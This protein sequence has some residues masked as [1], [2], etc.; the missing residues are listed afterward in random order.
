MF[1]W[2]PGK[3]ST[4]ATLR[5]WFKSY[6]DIRNTRLELGHLSILNQLHY[7]LNI[8][9]VDNIWRPISVALSMMRGK[10]FLKVQEYSRVKTFNF[11]RIRCQLQLIVI[12]KIFFVISIKLIYQRHAR[13]NPFHNVIFIRKL[14]FF[15]WSSWSCLSTFEGSSSHT[16]TIFYWI[17]WQKVLLQSFGSLVKIFLGST[18]H[19]YM[20]CINVHSNSSKKMLLR[21]AILV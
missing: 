17:Q 21:N 8:L 15:M 5:E 6:S 4:C 14:I 3:R 20:R 7:V 9:S 10:F 1:I 19:I 2:I 11:F 18:F 13:R 16:S 12:P